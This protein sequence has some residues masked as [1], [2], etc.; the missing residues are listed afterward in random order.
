MSC[1]YYIIE[2]GYLE[3]PQPPYCDK[4]K[5]IEFRCQDCKFYKEQAYMPLQRKVLKIPF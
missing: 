1:K 3:P 4:K 5:T 2:H